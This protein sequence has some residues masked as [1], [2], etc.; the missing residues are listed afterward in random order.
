MSEQRIDHAAEAAATSRD[1]NLEEGQGLA[2]DATH[3][4]A[5]ARDTGDLPLSGDERR[6]PDVPAD[7]DTEGEQVLRRTESQ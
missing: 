6:D 2:T 3:Q 4:H 5:G 7:G 1:T